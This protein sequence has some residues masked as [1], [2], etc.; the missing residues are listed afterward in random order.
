MC[1]IE[2]VNSTQCD[3]E[4]PPICR[5]MLGLNGNGVGYNNARP[6]SQYAFARTLGSDLLSA[7]L[8]AIELR[9]SMVRSQYSRGIRN[10]IDRPFGS[11]PCLVKLSVASSISEST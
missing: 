5:D 6:Y 4:Y 9:C 10:A 11:C 8:E 3:H 1:L 7:A 2:V